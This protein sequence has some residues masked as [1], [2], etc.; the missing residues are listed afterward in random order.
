MIKH[1]LKYRTVLS[2]VQQVSQ[3]KSFK[4]KMV[5]LFNNIMIYVL[6]FQEVDD[7][8]TEMYIKETCEAAIIVT[9]HPATAI[10]INVQE[11]EDSGG[12]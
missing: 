3:T 1:Q 12:V 4:L 6:I 11:L 8:M 10:C 2:K 5:Q 7:R 9:F